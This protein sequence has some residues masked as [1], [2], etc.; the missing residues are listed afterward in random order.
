MDDVLAPPRPEPKRYG[1]DPEH[2]RSC[3]ER[4]GFFILLGML[5]RGELT[6]HGAAVEAGIRKGRE[7][8]GSGSQNA[9]RTR[10]WKVQKA[11]EAAKRTG[12]QLGAGDLQYWQDDPPPASRTATRP[13]NGA[14]H[15]LWPD[16]EAALHELEEAR[17]PAPP[18]AR[19]PRDAEPDLELAR[20]RPEPAALPPGLERVSFPPHAALPCAGCH[21]PQAAA[22]LKQVIDAYV[23]ARRGVPIE[24]GN[25][26]PGA[27]CQRLLQGR[28]DIRAMIA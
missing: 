23:A 11:Y 3:L 19:R 14:V 5:Q 21:H 26:L 6:A 9:A 28:P 17:R 2:L 10:A 22:A 7:P 16:L 12:T 8:L 24:T 15:P 20:K 4:G 13:G 25:V 27:C 1:N 18:E